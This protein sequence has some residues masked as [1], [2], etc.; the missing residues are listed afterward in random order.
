[1]FHYIW[2][3]NFGV[4]RDRTARSAVRPTTSVQGEGVKSLFFFKFN[5]SEKQ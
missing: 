2:M 4:I 3:E 5:A 1:M